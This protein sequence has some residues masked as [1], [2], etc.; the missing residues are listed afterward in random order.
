MPPVHL[1]FLYRGNVF[2]RHV[3]MNFAKV[4]ATVFTQVQMSR[5]GFA[6]A[7]LRQKAQGETP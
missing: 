1:G 2:Y 5:R 3:S 7:A 4:S 6:I